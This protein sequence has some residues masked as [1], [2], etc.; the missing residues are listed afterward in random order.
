MD[1]QGGLTRYFA[2]LMPKY[3]SMKIAK[4]ER[5]YHRNGRLFQEVPFVAGKVNG[6]IREWHKN[7]TLAKEVPM[8]DGLRHGLCKEWNEK[9]DLLGQF[10]MNM[11]TGTSWH[12]FPNGQ[13]QFEISLISESF[14]GRQ[15]RWDEDGNLIEETYFLQN[16]RVSKEEYDRACRSDSSLPTYANGD[17]R[18]RSSR[19]KNGSRNGERLIK[20]LLETRK[21]EAVEWLKGHSRA[22]RKTLDELSARKSLSLISEL[23]DGGAV[24]VFAVDIDIDPKGN[25][26][27]DKL[28]VALPKDE[29]QRQAIRKAC[30]RRKMLVTPEQDA[31]HSHLAIVFG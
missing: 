2:C 21:A 15:R 22:S 12:W 28:V 10:E 29:A 20:R 24:K 8:K 11:G 31:G 30:A 4:F 27:S 17:G 26:H 5:S 7:G 13:L 3:N 9:G 6:V 25:E 19:Q 18:R 14:T 1:K 16:R 23:Y